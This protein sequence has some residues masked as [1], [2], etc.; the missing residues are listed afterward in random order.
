MSGGGAR[1][2]WRNNAVPTDEAD[3]GF[4]GLVCKTTNKNKE[5][6]CVESL[7]NH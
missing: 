2:T 4:G 3:S 5:G 1:W 6:E 7:G